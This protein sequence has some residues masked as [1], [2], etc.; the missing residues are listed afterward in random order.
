MFRL[1]LLLSLMGFGVTGCA[2]TANDCDPRNADIG[3][4]T[5]F[6]CT[7]Q[8]VYEQRVVQK[9]QVLQNEQRTNQLF[10]E[11]YRAIEQQQWAVSN[12]LAQQQR[13]AAEL[14]RSLNALLAELKKKS[15]G[16]QKMKKE[17]AGLEQQM[18]SLNQPNTNT[19]VMQ[20]QVE[21][22]KLRTR[23]SE[24]EGDLGLHN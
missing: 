12:D 13:Q 18:K 22:Q 2:V 9:Q 15:A 10:R 14:N 17:L 21:L 11:S 3:F 5:K 20:K 1:M 19:S 23:L 8:G 16:N 7:N 6:N 24:L 4:I